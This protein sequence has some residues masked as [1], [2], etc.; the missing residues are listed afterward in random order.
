VDVG[1]LLGRLDR[2]DDLLVLDVRNEEEY[3]EWRIEGRRPVATVHVPYF[4]FIEDA[5]AAL[6]RV[7]RGR[8]MVAL[9]AQGGSS[10]MIVGMLREAGIPARNLKG[11]MVAYGEYLQPVRVPVGAGEPFEL[12]QLNRRGKGCLSYVIV[13]GPEAIVVDAARQADRYVDFVHG[14]GARVVR[15]LDTHVHADHVSG[16][17]A[18]ARMT[19]A[20]YFVSAGEEFPLALPVAPLRDGAVLRLDGGARLEV[21]L[22]STPGHTPGSTSFLLG[23]RH[24]LSGDT[25][26]VSGVGRPDLGGRVVEWGRTLFHTS[27]ER[28]ASLAD[29]TV[30]LPAHYARVSEIGADGVVSARLGELRRTVPEMRIAGEQ[31]FVSAV[32]AAVGRPPDAYAEIIKVNLGQAHPSGDKITEWELGRNQCALAGKAKAAAL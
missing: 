10:E 9:C 18:L 25:L 8:D 22:L 15:V 4:D 21:R 11:G 1:T 20:P 5:P 23:A 27:H 12:W 7:P 17:P 24:L 14:R 3:R 6:A 29:E 32:R 2:G 19:G 26:F 30:V 28:I 31:E 13:S 16:G